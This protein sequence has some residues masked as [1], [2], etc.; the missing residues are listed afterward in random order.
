MQSGNTI[1]EYGN[2]M[3]KHCNEVVFF[4]AFS[5][6]ND[7]G[8]ISITDY[9]QDRSTAS[10]S[11]SF[12]GKERDEETGYGYFGARYMDHELMTM[13][14]S[15]DPM[16]DKYPSI[17][18]Y[19]YCVW[20]P[21]KLVDS[22]GEDP[23]KPLV[24]YMGQGTFMVNTANLRKTT[25]SQI[26]LANSMGTHDENSIGVN[27][28]IGSYQSPIAKPVVPSPVL[29]K[30]IGIEQDYVYNHTPEKGN[31]KRN[32]RPYY[33]RYN[34]TSCAKGP[35][36]GRASGISFFALNLLIYSADMYQMASIIKDNRELQRQVVL[37]NR[38]TNMVDAAI[39]RG[40]IF[41]EEQASNS[42]FLGDVINYIF[43]G[44]YVAQ[45][46]TAYGREI[47]QEAIRKAEEI[48]AINGV[49]YP[50]VSYQ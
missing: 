47:S 41:S 38:A 36:V 46:G 48:K 25:R 10:W 33:N 30:A 24:K 5:S 42:D 17:S 6:K 13:W 2:A 35:G 4:C 14:L 9:K 39:T 22:D 44:S 18:P 37:L 28:C 23:I 31:L 50:L 43:Q 40:G 32:G 11:C 19:A 49:K 45:G 20:N 15:V 27:L 8:S 1:S 3:Y 21:V 29:Q 34:W 16:A 26:E 7:C 12:T